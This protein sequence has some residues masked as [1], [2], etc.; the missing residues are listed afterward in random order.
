MKAN[1]RRH[2]IANLLLTEKKPITGAALSAKFGVSRQIIVHNIFNLVSMGFLAAGS[3]ESTL[4]GGDNSGH[5]LD[6]PTLSFDSLFKTVNLLQQML[7]HM[8]FA[9]QLAHKTSDNCVQL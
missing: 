6:V 4:V 1:E 5:L 8:V 7:N 9:L 2:A 3:E